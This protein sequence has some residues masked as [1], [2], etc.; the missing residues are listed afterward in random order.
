MSQPAVGQS[1]WSEAVG[2][3]SSR[4]AD[5]IE[6][7]NHGES[8]DPQATHFGIFHD[9]VQNEVQRLQNGLATVDGAITELTKTFS[10][11]GKIVKA[12]SK[13]WGTDEVLE[14][15]I[16]NLKATNAGIWNNIERDR[17]KHEAEISDLK[18]EHAEEVSGLQEE[19]GAGKQEKAQYEEM[20]RHIEEQ[21][22][23]AMQ[24]MDAELKQKKTQLEDE[25]AKKILDLE[26]EKSELE[27]AKAKLEQQLEQRTK[28]LDQE[29]ETRTTMQDK[30]R[31]DVKEL[32]TA[33]SEIKAKYQ[34]D[35][36][37]L[38]F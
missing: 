18:R 5:G 10:R 37:P 22:N 30:L 23:E 16:R 21:H 20:K 9:Q 33:L 7:T 24:N 8:A 12:V 26:R 25:N 14:E 4:I 31:K 17:K 13:R 36:R 27:G 38:E 15:E 34:V 35:K 1:Q 3:D 2:G 19:A 29:K 6:T 32:Q 28:E 11:H